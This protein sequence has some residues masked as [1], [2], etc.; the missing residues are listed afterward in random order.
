MNDLFAADVPDYF[1]HRVVNHCQEYPDN[2]YVFQTKNPE[3]YL[4]MGR[5]IPDNSILGC[6]IET[7]R[8]IPA[9]VSFAPAPWIRASMMVALRYLRTF[10]TIEPIM[11]FDVPVIGQWLME[12]RPEFINIGA[13]SKRHGL[14]EPSADKIMAL[15]D[16]LNAAGIEIREKHNL[17]RLLSK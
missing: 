5:I 4:T 1:I 17:E 10:I 8:E 14:P 6:T 11:D 7:N 9:S 3:R 2:L 15:I 13:D 16:V 12:I